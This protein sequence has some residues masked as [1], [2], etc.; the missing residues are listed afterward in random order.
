MGYILKRMYL[1]HF[2]SFTLG[3]LC[4]LSQQDITSYLVLRFV[5]TDLYMSILLELLVHF[6]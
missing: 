5:P 2:S 4:H 1:F 6:L 3:F